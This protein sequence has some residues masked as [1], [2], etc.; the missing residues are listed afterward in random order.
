MHETP[1]SANYSNGNLTQVPKNL[2]DKLNVL[3]LDHNEI[4]KIENNTFSNLKLLI[5]L[6]INNNKLEILESKA[7]IGLTSLKTLKMSGNN[8]D[9]SAYTPILFSFIAKISFLDISRNLNFSKYAIQSNNYPD[10]A[11]GVLVNLE[12]LAIDLGPKPVFGKGFKKMDKLKVLEFDNCKVE[13]LK[14]STFMNFNW[15]IEYLHMNKCQHFVKAEED[16]LK[17]FPNLKVL[18]LSETYMHPIQAFQ[19]LKPLLNRT[20]ERINFHHVNDESIT[21]NS[22][23]SFEVNITKEMVKY[24]QTMCVEVLDISKNNIVDFE[25]G[26]LLTFNRPEC[27][28]NISLS[29]NR[30]S[31][32]HAHRLKNIKQFFNRAQNLMKFEYSYIPLSFVNYSHIAVKNLTNITEERVITLPSSIKEVHMS[33]VYHSGQPVLWKIP[34]NASIKCFD[35]SFC[36]TVDQATASNGSVIEYLDVTGV[37]SRVVFDKIQLYPLFKLKTLVMKNTNLYITNKN[38]KNIFT[39][40]SGTEKLDISNNFLWKLPSDI[41]ENMT[42]LT[43]LDLSN[44][45]FRAVPLAITRIANLKELDLSKNLLTNINSTFQEFFD[46]LYAKHGVFKL[47]LDYNALVCD[48][49]NYD[50][51]RW[52]HKTNKT[53][54]TFDANGYKCLLHNSTE[55]NT[56]IA[57]VHFK[58]LFAGCNNGLWLKAG[59]CLIL[60]FIAIFFPFTLIYSFRWRISFYLYKRFRHTL[61]KGIDVKFKYDVFV[62]YPESDLSWIKYILMPELE[63][64]W[65][66]KMCIEHRDFPVGRPIADTFADCIEQSRHIIFIV[67]SAFK[68]DIWGQYAVERAKY[69]HF[70][71]NLQKIIVITKGINMEEIPHELAVL[72]KDLALIAWPDDNDK[73][74]ENVWNKLRLWLFLNH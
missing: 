48:C 45:L 21:N 65:G 40:I 55:T 35:V 57:A 22:T 6:T 3:I 56:N 44:N 29:E 16:T 28:L 66:L 58:E 70:S 5:E 49:T 15:G 19:L 59:I 4:Q 41:F 43:N 20:M 32:F 72:W 54:F 62:Y 23:Y 39:F 46:V 26:S 42:R 50:F 8:L 73:D 67:T 9:F 64:K 30:F 2:S 18:D 63:R 34:P 37:D 68:N 47:H 38:Q 14:Y 12:T 24:I 7:F 1:C 74:L 17:Y 10:K 53:N 52:L 61:E 51:I 36:V 31:L 69:H 33:H 71:Q 27:L 25:D 60:T 13:V 11:L